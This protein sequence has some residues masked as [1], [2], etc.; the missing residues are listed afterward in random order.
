MSS[1]Y[2]AIY[3]YIYIYIYS[4]IPTGTYEL[5]ALLQLVHCLKCTNPKALKVCLLYLSTTHVSIN[6]YLSFPRGRAE[7]IKLALSAVQ[8]EWEFHAIADRTEMKTNLNLYPFG[9]A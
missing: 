4:Y 6:T 3:S 9:E 5:V 2:I 8:Q 7:V 1:V